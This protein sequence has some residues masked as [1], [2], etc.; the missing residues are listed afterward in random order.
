VLPSY[1]QAFLEERY[2]GWSQ[3]QEG[4]MLCVLLPNF[5]LPPG[6]TVDAANL[7][8]RLSPGYPDLPP[9]MWWF[10][11]FICRRDGATIEQTNCHEVYLGRVWQRWSRHLNPGHWRPGVDSLESYMSLVN[12]QLAL[13]A[14]SIAA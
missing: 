13:A 12:S 6:F 2:P 8:I 7:L 5:L 9:D 4:G 3:V 11:P 1:D 14:R 10:E